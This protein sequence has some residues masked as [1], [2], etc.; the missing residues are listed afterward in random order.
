MLS[1]I[2]TLYFIKKRK[3]GRKTMTLSDMID[4]LGL[5]FD[6]VR[7]RQSQLMESFPLPFL[8]LVPMVTVIDEVA[9]FC[10]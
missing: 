7:M 9:G 8:S 3:D 6:F 4:G 5:S 10:T 2:G 1:P